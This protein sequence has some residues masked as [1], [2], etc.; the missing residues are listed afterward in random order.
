MGTTTLDT[1]LPQ[2]GRTI[3][4]YIGSFTTTTNI[5]SGTSVG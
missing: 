5:G 2:Y 3:G 1:M 4:A